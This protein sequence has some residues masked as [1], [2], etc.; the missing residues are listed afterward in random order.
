[1]VKTKP[2]KSAKLRRLVVTARPS[3]QKTHGRLHA[4]VNTFACAIGASS[5]RRHKRE[6]D[7]ATPAGHFR[8]I[9]GFF[10]PGHRPATLIPM[11]VL[12]KAMGWCEDP[13]AA[14]YN[15]LVRLPSHDGHER[16]WRD[17]E[18]Y[19]IV[20]VLDYN[21]RPRRRN[22]GSAIFMH[23]ARP[24]FS[25]TLGCV[26]LRAEDLRKLLPRLARDALLV[27]R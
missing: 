19:D 22:L 16:M 15:R 13:A 26:A 3:S 5:I 24:D 1:M 10:K 21:M 23:C 9:E 18:L 7:R 20:L 27:V 17:D 12:T 11:R 8:L 14:S 2:I 25:P 4:G 6:G